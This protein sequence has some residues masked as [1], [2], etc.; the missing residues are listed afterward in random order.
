MTFR[1]IV[2]TNYKNKN[3]DLNLSKAAKG[4]KSVP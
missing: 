3:L 4:V 1:Y 2:L